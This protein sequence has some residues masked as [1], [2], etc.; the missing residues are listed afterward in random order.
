MNSRIWGII[1]GV[2][3]VLAL[4][5]PLLLGNANKIKQLFEEAEV[6]YAQENY[7]G[8][9]IKYREALKESKKLGANTERIDADF[10]TLVNLKIAWCYYELSE[11]TSDVRHNQNALTH[12]K[13]DAS[14]TQVPRYQEE[15]TYLWAENLYKIDNLNQATS[16]FE[17]LIQ[18]FPRSQWV[19]K[20]LCTLAEIAYQQDNC[21]KA[22][23]ILQKLVTEFPESELIQ[24]AER[25]IVELN[26]AC[27]K[28]PPPPPYPCEEM[29]NTAFALQQD[30]CYNEA[31]ERYKDLIAQ[32]PDNEYVVHA[33]VGIAE[34][35][36]EV[37]DYVNARLNYE[38]AIYNTTDEGEKRE[39]YAA[40]HRTYLVPDPVRDDRRQ[41]ESDDDLFVIARLLRLEERWLEA[42]QTYEKLT[43][44]NLPVEDMTYSL[45]WEGRCYYE[46]AQRDWTLFRKS[47]D[48]LTTLT[49]DYENSEY[50][51]ESYYYLT[52]AYKN[53]AKV[54]DS[55]CQ[56]VIDTVDQADA[57]YKDNNDSKVQEWLGY[58]RKLKDK[59]SK[60]FHPD[61]HP[62]KEEAE[63]AIKHAETAI[64]TATQENREPRIIHQANQHLEC[65]KHEKNKSNYAAAIDEAKKVLECLKRI[66]SPPNCQDYVD[67]GN[68]YL[69]NSDLEDALK[70]AEEALDLDRNFT[71]AHELKSR[72]KERYVAR[73]EL[74]FEEEKYDEAIEAFN[75]AININIPVKFKEPHN[76]LGIIYIRQEKYREAIDSF[77][78]AIRI[79]A[80]FKEA[81]FNRALVH[82]ELGD[83]EEAIVNAEDALRIDPNY[84]PARTLI[85]FIT[86]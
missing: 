33:Y 78:K 16:K 39:L 51:F 48:A 85:A 59:A 50:D 38:E 32:Y 19:P 29:Y 58:M 76:Y 1:G 21:E 11:R 52:L 83:F 8:A 67:E 31:Y 24:K 30:G 22:L 47:V 74:F 73:G 86:D 18:K 82:L 77:S 66:P 60:K 57:K 35:Y 44:R 4:L 25:R 81:Y 72:I 69:E 55:K 12:I 3:L 28:L 84:E 65:A 26:E 46:A 10:T 68:A 54:D 63:K 64:A 7:D 6:L 20:A 40:Y 34:I 2:A 14:D 80:N 9:L 62:L 70:K 27:N 36:L 23:N 45:Y 61:P 13:V 5:S 43:D 41:R 79:D 56:S 37:K 75:T 49:T 71:P 17:Q 42:A 15:R 53:W